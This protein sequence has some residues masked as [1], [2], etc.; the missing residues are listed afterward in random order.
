M[1][2]KKNK[3]DRDRENSGKRNQFDID[4]SVRKFATI[5][6]KSF[7]KKNKDYFDGKKEMRKGY[8]LNLIDNLPQVIKFIVKYGHIDNNDVRS[9]RDGALAKLSNE[10]FIKAVRKE[11]KLDNKIDNIKLLPIINDIIL[12]EAVK[13][14]AE[15]LAENANA[16][17]YDVEPLLDLS[18][19]ILKKKLK[20][21]E[22]AGIPEAIAF[23]VL[24][25]IPCNEALD[26]SQFYRVRTFFD[27][28]YE[29]SKTQ[30][31]PFANIMDLI[32]G[33]D[34]FPMFITFAL[35][36]RKEKFTKLTDNQKTLYLDISTWCFDQ[37]E[38]K[39]SSDVVRNIIKMYIKS[40]KHDDSAGKDSNRRYSLISLPETDY[41]KIRKIVDEMVAKDDSIKKYL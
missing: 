11:L 14:N 34:K 41:K 19:A 12:K 3:H 16:E 23:D 36:E 10:E 6:F 22:K 5:D 30:A 7:K 28:L 39:L 24:S 18:K 8:I 37:M 4:K 2:K 31:I 1:A 29:S 25:V 13:T 21:F 26:S 32:T 35:L 20:K 17:V 27:R 9:V 33:E 40:R 15:R 38:N